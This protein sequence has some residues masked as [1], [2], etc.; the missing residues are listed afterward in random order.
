MENSKIAL[1]L[2]KL[3]ELLNII[4]N[5]RNEIQIEYL[6]DQKPKVSG[7]QS[8]QEFNES[9]AGMANQSCNNQSCQPATNAICQNQ[10]C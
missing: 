3:D 2:A 7:K 5:I 8:Y 9:C 1:F 6:N 4:P 10:S